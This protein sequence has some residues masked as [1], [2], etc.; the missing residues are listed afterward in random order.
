[1]YTLTS[2]TSSSLMAVLVALLGLGQLL[3]PAQAT[4]PVIF[5]HRAQRA[6]RGLVGAVEAAGSLAALDHKPGRLQ[7]AQVLADRRPGHVEVGRD[8]PGGQLPVPDQL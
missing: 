3:D 8:L 1:M 4:P 6:Q 7:H 5:D 2:T